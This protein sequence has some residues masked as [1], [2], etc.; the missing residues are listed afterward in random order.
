MFPVF[1]PRCPGNANV[2]V[3]RHVKRRYDLCIFRCM[4]KQLPIVSLYAIHASYL[5]RNPYN[6]NSSL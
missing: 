3:C 5:S 1:I 2:A 6:E 4:L